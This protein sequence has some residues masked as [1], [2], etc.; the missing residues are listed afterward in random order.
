ME[1]FDDGGVRAAHVPEFAHGHAGAFWSAV[2]YVDDGDAGGDKRTA[3]I[4]SVLALFLAV[5]E[6]GAKSS[7]TEALATIQ[8]LDPVYVDIQQSSADLLKLR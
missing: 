8:R 5:A 4:I 6:T 7:Q 1:A 3:L 2:Y